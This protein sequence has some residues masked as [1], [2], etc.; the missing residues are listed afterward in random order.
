M[1]L[2]LRAFFKILKCKVEMFFATWAIQFWTVEAVLFF[3]KV[4]F[5]TIFQQTKCK[6]VNEISICTYWINVH[7]STEEPLSSPAQDISALVTWYW[8]HAPGRAIGE[9]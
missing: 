1:L 7:M 8:S 4:T 6:V 3:L 5:K 9:G 2:I